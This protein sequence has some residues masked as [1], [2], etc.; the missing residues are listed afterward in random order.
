MLGEMNWY[1]VRFGVVHICAYEITF[2]FQVNAHFKLWKI[3]ASLNRVFISQDLILCRCFPS[4]AFYGFEVLF[5]HWMK[6]SF[7]FIRHSHVEVSISLRKVCHSSL[8][9]CIVLFH[10]I[11]PV[12]M[13][14]CITLSQIQCLLTSC[15]RTKMR[16][17]PLEGL[18]V[19]D[20]MKC[21][22]VLWCDL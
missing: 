15:T 3:W 16:T 9:Q 7:L 13:G 22:A 21:V 6:L 18:W 2:S 5:R 11:F 19:V 14:C 12:R 1:L 4:C 8:V 20:E 17:V 10:S